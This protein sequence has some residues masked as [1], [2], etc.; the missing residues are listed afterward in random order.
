[1]TQPA[2]YGGNID[3]A[4][5]ASGS[6]EMS[7]IVMSQRSEAAEVAPSFNRDV[8]GD[9]M[10]HSVRKT[11]QTPKQFLQCRKDGDRAAS[12]AAFGPDDW[13]ATDNHRPFI[14]IN[15]PPFHIGCLTQT[16]S[17][18]SEKFDEIGGM[19]APT[20]SSRANSGDEFLKFL[21][22]GQIQFPWF[23]TPLFQFGSWVIFSHAHANCCT[24]NS[25]QGAE[26]TIEAWGRCSCEEKLVAPTLAFG[27]A[28]AARWQSWQ[29]APRFQDA[30][31]RLA[32][33]SFTAGSEIGMNID[34]FSIF[35]D[36]LA[37][38]NCGLILWGGGDDACLKFW[39]KKASHCF[40]LGAQATA[41][42]FTFVANDRV[43]DPGECIFT[44]ICN[45]SYFYEI[46]HNKEYTNRVYEC[47]E[48][49]T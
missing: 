15:I 36:D 48:V 10:Q 37:H 45:P 42:K 24:K 2:G 31:E 1:M 22:G 39:V 14:K 27:R 38:G 41:Y 46:S 16:A 26:A 18:V 23:H 7:Q 44:K 32:A 29:F 49:L 5:Q 17:G 40:R 21:A 28:Q 8:A 11:W 4:L 30:I 9:A 3:S 6:E 13:I 25:T 20:T 43:V 34:K 12:S 33:I 19:L 35:L 47:Q